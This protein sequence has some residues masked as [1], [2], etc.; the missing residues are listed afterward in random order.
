MSL[1]HLIKRRQWWEKRTITKV[2]DPVS[3]TQTTTT[4][5]VKVFSYFLRQKFRPILVDECVRQMAG[6][7]HPRLSEEWKEALDM[8]LTSNELEVPLYKEESNKVPGRDGIGF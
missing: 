4:G 2:Q 6:T 5:I 8:P 1:F 3:G 7:G